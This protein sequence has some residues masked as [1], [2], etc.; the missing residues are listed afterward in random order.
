MLTSGTL[1]NRLEF[2][3]RLQQYIELRRNGRLVEAR[4]HAQKYLIQHA[5]TYLEEVNRAA[6]L[7]AYPPDT[8]VR[9]Y[10]VSSHTEMAI[11]WMLTGIEIV[12]GK[13]VGRP[14]QTLRQHPPRAL[15]TPRT[16]TPPHSA[17]CRTFGSQDTFL[18][19]ETCQQY[20]KCEFHDHISLSD[21]LDGA[22]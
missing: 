20:S 10:R 1:Q 2:E 6:G 22:K 8:Q 15:L 21:L 9:E 4:Q 3:L 5:G 13:S 7:L 16:T 11:A 12:L 19:F 18:P 14:R 17:F